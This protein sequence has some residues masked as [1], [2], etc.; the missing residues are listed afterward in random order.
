MKSKRI[1]KLLLLFFLLFFWL[2]LSPVSFF[3]KF[4]YAYESRS[5]DGQYK[6]VAY[7]VLPTTPYAVYQCFINK[8]IFVVLYD[9]DGKYLGQSSPFHFSGVEGVFGDAVFF[10]G[11]LTGDDSFSING[12]SDYVDGY[13]ISSKYKKWWSLV[14]SLFH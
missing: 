14:I 6:A 9:K 2:V 10:P 7:Y 4:N 3:G 8:D 1:I 5:H 12:V 11:E 13:S